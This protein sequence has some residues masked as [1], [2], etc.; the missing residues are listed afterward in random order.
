MV[1]DLQRPVDF[2]LYWLS[3]DLGRAVYH[4][5]FR[6][7][8]PFIFGALAFH[9][10]L[11]V[12]VLDVFVVHPQR[13]PRRLFSFAMRFLV[14]VLAFWI[15]DYRGVNGM[16]GVFWTFLSGSVVPLAIIPSPG[17]A[18]PRYCRSQA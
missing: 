3:Q 5:L 2:Q 18:S 8:P 16:A 9:L 11:P 13:R 1:T 10:F 7:I 4:A 14:N 6:G 12:D 15:L 17:G